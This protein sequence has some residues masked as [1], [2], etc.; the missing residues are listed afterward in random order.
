MLVAVCL[1]RRNHI[2]LALKRTLRKT[3]AI[4]KKGSTRT[5][6]EFYN[7]DFDAEHKITRDARYSPEK[8]AA[9]W[10]QS[11]INVT[12]AV[13]KELEMII[14]I[15]RGKVVAKYE[16]EVPV[17]EE[18]VVAYDGLEELSTLT[19]KKLTGLYKNATGEDPTFDDK[20]DLAAKTWSALEAVTLEAAKERGTKEKRVIARTYK[21]VKDAEKL[22]KQAQQIL[23][24]IKEKGEISRADLLVAMA[25]VVVTKQTQERILGFYEKTLKD[26]VAAV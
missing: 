17:L 25:E 26:F 12:E 3:T 8:I 20:A 23:D 21:F 10:L 19:P 16:G 7:S 24:I 18:G 22:P 5:I 11:Q 14:A 9:S 2:V 1:D 13:R 15:K 4:V 6:R